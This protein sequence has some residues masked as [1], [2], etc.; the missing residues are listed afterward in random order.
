MFATEK[1][2]KD[3]KASSKISQDGQPIKVNVSN[4]SIKSATMNSALNVKKPV[5]ASD[6]EY[7]EDEYNDFE[8]DED[9]G[10]EMHDSIIQ[11]EEE[12]GGATLN[13]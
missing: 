5:K 13:N 8:N 3:F 11:D 10:Q 1:T 7:E 12:V 4:P 6:D 2:V 9:Y